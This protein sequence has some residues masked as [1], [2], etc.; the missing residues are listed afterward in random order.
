MS[1]YTT[2][3]RYICEVGAGYSESKPATSVIDV[4]DKSWEHI[5]SF[6]FP[7]F[8]ETYRK[9]LCRKILLHYYTREIA[10]E[11]YALWNLWLMARMNEIMPYYNKLY[12]LASLKIDPIKDVDLQTKHDGTSQGTG[13]TTDTFTI[14]PETKTINSTTGS[15]TETNSGGTRDIQGFSDTPMGSLD[16]VEQMNYLSSA[17][18]NVHSDNRSNVRQFDGYQNTT[19]QKGGNTNEHS[20]NITDTDSYVQSVTGKSAGSSYGKLI[21][22]YRDSLQNVDMMIIRDLGDLF[23]TIW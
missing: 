12:E 14:S 15:I 16:S 13:S 20:R 19:E 2:E 7:I 1:K 22:E 8:D 10:A 23:M 5:F 11:T 21:K 3:L 18:Q 6:S 4:I 17:Q 9:V